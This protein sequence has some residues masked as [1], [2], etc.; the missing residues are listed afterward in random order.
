MSKSIFGK[1]QRKTFY[2]EKKTETHK[3]ERGLN[4][5]GFDPQRE[6]GKN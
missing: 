4:T 6:N 2:W 1:V 5:K 3:T